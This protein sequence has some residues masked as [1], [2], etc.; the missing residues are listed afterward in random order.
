METCSQLSAAAGF[1]NG[2]FYDTHLGKVREDID[3]ISVS[4]LNSFS[5]LFYRTSH[6]FS[7]Y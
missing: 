4:L 7:D 3:V 6:K 5:K 2:R 1:G